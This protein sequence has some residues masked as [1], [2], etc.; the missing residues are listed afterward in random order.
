MNMYN[1][2][3]HSDNY[4]DSTASLYQFKR[5]ELLADNADLTVAGSSSFQYKSN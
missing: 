4:E 2:I 1:L 5:Q 3:E